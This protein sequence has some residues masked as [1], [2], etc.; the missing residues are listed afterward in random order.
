MADGAAPTG[1]SDAA[2]TDQLPELDPLPYTGT[3]APAAQRPY[4]GESDPPLQRPP[5]RRDGSSPPSAPPTAPASYRPG[6]PIRR[7]ASADQPGADP[8]QGPAERRASVTTPA[9]TG[10]TGT[11]ATR[12]E[13]TRIGATGA[14]PDSGYRETGTGQPTQQEVNLAG[15]NALTLAVVGALLTVA[16]FPVGAILDVVALVFAARA[17]GQAHRARVP[18]RAGRIALA[19]GIPATAFA[20]LATLVIGLFWRESWS[21]ATC[22]RDALTSSASAACT[23]TFQQDVQTRVDSW[24][25]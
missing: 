22:R 3:S 7:P 5:E 16:F 13:A 11:E 24:G 17:I 23:T 19:V 21:W 18:A 6:E 25:G 14:R 4:A 10:D 12:T 8:G 1:S 9:E 15:R 20:V 2:A